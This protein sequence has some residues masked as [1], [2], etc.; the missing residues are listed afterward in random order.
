[1]HEQCVRQRSGIILN[2]YP[3]QGSKSRENDPGL[4]TDKPGNQAD[5]D[6]IKNRK[7]QQKTR[8]K[9]TITDHNDHNKCSDQS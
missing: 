2:G 3:D 4:Q 7:S 6:Q 1:M 5:R 9:I 8:Y